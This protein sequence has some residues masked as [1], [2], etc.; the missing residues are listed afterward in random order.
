[1]KKLLAWLFVMPVIASSFF[2]AHDAKADYSQFISTASSTSQTNLDQRLGTGL[3]GTVNSI[4]VSC[5]YSGGALVAHSVSLTSYTD[6]AYSVGGVTYTFTTSQT[7]SSSRSILTFT[8]TGNT[9]FSSN[10]YWVLNQNLFYVGGSKA[11]Y[12]SSID[13]YPNGACVVSGVPCTDL[14]DIYFQIQNTQ[15]DNSSRIVENISPSAGSITASSTVPFSFSY[16]YNDSNSLYDTVGY[17]LTDITANTQIAGVEQSI[18]ASGG[19]TYTATSTLVANHFYSWRPYMK[20]SVN[21]SFIYGDLDTFS[22]LTNTAPV[23]PLTD[24]F[25]TSTATTTAP[26][27]YLNIV[28]LLQNKY[29]ISYVPQIITLVKSEATLTGTS[30]FPNLT[31]DFTNTRLGSTTLNL[32]TVEMF[33]TSTITY[34]FH[35]TQIDQFKTL[36]RYVLWVS[37]ILFLVRDIRRTILKTRV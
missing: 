17:E 31:F 5:S 6:S 19:N 7:C 21:G 32:S 30:T 14:S 11:I 16:F 13:V 23:S 28:S 9:V 26:L 2:I 27:I 8:P 24:P 12:G 22:V 29:P 1:M 37:F 36:I 33:G 34:F 20:Y 4:S 3:T 18:N 25:A 35:Q 10:L 15:E